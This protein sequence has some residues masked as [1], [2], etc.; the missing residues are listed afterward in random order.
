MKYTAGMSGGVPTLQAARL[1]GLKVS[2]MREFNPVRLGSLE[3]DAWV[4]YYQHRWLAFLRAAVGMVREGFRM[5]WPKTVVGALLV[6]RANQL[7]APVP[8]NDPDGARR[9]MRRFYRLLART[10]GAVFDVDEAARLE[11]EW[12]GVHRHLQRDADA[13]R[14]DASLVDALAAVTA[15]VYAVTPDEVRESARE[16]AD[17]MRTSDRWVEEGCEPDSGLIALERAALVRSY[18]ALL[19]AVHR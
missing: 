17:A 18:A 15:H 1:D 4:A 14:D 11:V 8:D 6:L 5:S 19:A 2:P 12:W 9:T 3:S 10:H 13:P 16:R 7:W